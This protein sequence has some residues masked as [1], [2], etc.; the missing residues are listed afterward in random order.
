MLKS[1]LNLEGVQELT[2][3]E[4]RNLSGGRGLITQCNADCGFVGQVCH[5]NNLCNEPGRC[6]RQG[7]INNG[8]GSTSIVCM[9][10]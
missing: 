6:R 8:V 2:K 1:I 7:S 4:Q 9:P 3:N 5:P 10:L